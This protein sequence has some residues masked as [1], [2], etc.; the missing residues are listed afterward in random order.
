M[1]GFRQWACRFQRL[2]GRIKIQ[3]LSK[4]EWYETFFHDHMVR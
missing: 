3:G 2:P 4:N 1:D